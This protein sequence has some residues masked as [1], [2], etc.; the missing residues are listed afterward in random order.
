MVDRVKLVMLVWWP[1]LLESPAAT[2]EVK[3]TL[4]FHV[5]HVLLVV[6]EID[7]RVAVAVAVTVAVEVVLSVVLLVAVPSAIA[8]GVRVAV[9]V[10]VVDVKMVP[11]IVAEL[12]VVVVAETELALPSVVVVLGAGTVNFQK[13]CLLW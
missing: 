5:V 12:D 2:A 10:K 8:T 11:E 6:D 7:E 9:E 3:V 4:T 1:G 13:S